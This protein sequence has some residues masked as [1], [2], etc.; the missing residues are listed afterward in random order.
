[1]QSQRGKAAHELEDPYK[2]FMDQE[3]DIREARSRLC[4]V[5]PTV[6]LAADRFDRDE[7]SS[8]AAGVGCM[9]M[10]ASSG[11]RLVC[12]GGAEAFLCTQA[13]DARLGDSSSDVI[14]DINK[15]AAVVMQGLPRPGAGAVDEHDPDARLARSREASASGRG[16]AEG[17]LLEDLRGPWVAGFSELR[18]QDPK[19]CYEGVGAAGA[20]PPETGTE[21]GSAEHVQAA[22]RQVQELR[23]TGLASP[24]VDAGA[25]ARVLSEL[26]QQWSS[27]SLP[28]GGPQAG[29]GG[30]PAQLL[31]P[32]LQSVLRETVLTSNE[33]LRHFWGAFPL[34]SPARE[35]RA[36]RL[37]RALADQFDRTT[38]MQESSHGTERAR[39]TQLLRPLRHALDTALAKHDREVDLRKAGQQAPAP[40][41]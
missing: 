39:I 16:T 1:M 33:L 21:V 22:L 5:D 12:A 35:A 10:E 2:D 37:K 19:R 18:I 27:A 9:C 32:Q 13:Q 11:H 40:Q 3:H 4:Y 15:H 23:A 6:N 38:A 36:L 26:C 29:A 24:V 25:A 28:L 8:A 34:T 7:D 14:R 20:A 30:D 31:V 41:Q 17:L